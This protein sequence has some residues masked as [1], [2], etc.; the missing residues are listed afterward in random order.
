MADPI[1]VVVKP[2]LVS[3]ISTGGGAVVA[4]PPNAQGGI[5]TNPELDTD[6]GVANIEP[7]F[8]NPIDAANLTGN[9]NTFAL[10]PGQTWVVIP[11]QTTPTSVN[12]A[13]AGHKFSVVWW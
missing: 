11:G 2:G 9:G 7:L 5:I 1:A 4:V 10:A 12:A 6:Q 3:V 13:T 8:V